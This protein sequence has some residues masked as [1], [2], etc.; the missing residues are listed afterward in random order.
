MWDTYKKHL[1]RGCKET[2]SQGTMVDEQGDFTEEE[3]TMDTLGCLEE[4]N[5]NPSKF[6]LLHVGTIMWL[7]CGIE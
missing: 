7:S 5:N 3:D 2:A 4:D 6:I 1:Y